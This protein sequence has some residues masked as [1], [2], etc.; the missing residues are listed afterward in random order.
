VIALV[1][2]LFTVLK[3]DNNEVVLARLIADA[4]PDEKEFLKALDEPDPV[5]PKAI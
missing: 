3:L 4:D 1:F 2:E 5:N